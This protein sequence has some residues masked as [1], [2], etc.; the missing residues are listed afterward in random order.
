MSKLR[1][2]RFVQLASGV[3]QEEQVYGGFWIK[4]LYGTFWAG[5]S[6]L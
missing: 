6:Q 4:A 1:S 3:V 5:R 2:I